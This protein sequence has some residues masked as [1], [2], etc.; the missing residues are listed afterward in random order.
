M[1]ICT[2]DE[3][4]YFGL[5]SLR[6]VTDVEVDNTGSKRAIRPFAASCFKKRGPAF[7]IQISNVA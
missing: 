4:P 2:D 3:H 6:V 5:V 7:S 1:M